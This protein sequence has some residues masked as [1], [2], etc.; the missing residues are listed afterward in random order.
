MTTPP[1]NLT[2]HEF[3]KLHNACPKGSAFAEQFSTMS[4][5]WDSCPAVDWL[6]WIAERHKTALDDKSL[7]LF[8]VWCARSCS[9]KDPRSV[10]AIDVAER[11]AN[12]EASEKDLTAAWAAASAAASASFWWPGS[13]EAAA[14]AAARPASSAAESAASAALAAVWATRASSYEGG[15][16]GGSAQCDQFRLLFANPF[17]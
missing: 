8:A 5:V 11:F 9:P 12:G 10:G 2:P 7:R 14:A 1:P 15:A 6:L 3:C 17:L 4:E 13:A 16:A